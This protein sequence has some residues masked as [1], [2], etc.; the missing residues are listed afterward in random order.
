MN[1][2]PKAIIVKC[3]F[4]LVTL[5]LATIVSA[6]DRKMSRQEVLNAFHKYI[7]LNDDF[8]SSLK[9]GKGKSGKSYKDLR[10]EAEAYAEGPFHEAL[11]GT[12]K[13]ICEKGDS[14]VLVGLFKVICS[15]SNSADESPSW[16]LGGIFVCQ[17]S[18]IEKEIARLKPEDRKQIYDTLEFGF[19]NVATTKPKDDK[20]IID[21]RKRLAAMAS[22]R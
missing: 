6:N 13:I 18:L 14:E 1:T 16:T 19:E 5:S 7:T 15:T 8:I 12:E 17:P 3:L 4:A 10:K 2:I 20:L 9:T 11:S 22:S 21:L